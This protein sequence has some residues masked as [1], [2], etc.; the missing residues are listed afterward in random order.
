[1]MKLH[2][3]TPE[4]AST[5]TQSKKVPWTMSNRG[6]HKSMSASGNWKCDVVWNIRL[7][8]WSEHEPTLM[9]SRNQNSED[10]L[11]E[12]SCDV[13]KTWGMERR[14]W[15]WFQNAQTHWWRPEEE[16]I[17]FSAQEILF[18]SFRFRFCIIDFHPFLVVNAVFCRMRLRIYFS[19]L[20]FFRFILS[21]IL[22]IFRIFRPTRMLNL[23]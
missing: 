7:N 18:L 4:S 9:L 2:I 3:A 21:R 20:P 12:N 15:I 23:D 5:V 8:P 22:R 10:A 13:F 19:F 11:M 17:C 14:W 16:C 6:S 1:M